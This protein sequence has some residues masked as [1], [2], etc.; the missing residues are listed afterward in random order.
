MCGWNGAYYRTTGTGLVRRVSGRCEAVTRE[1][2][3]L[4]LRTGDG[5]L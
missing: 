2:G 3:D 4:G 1:E 5:E